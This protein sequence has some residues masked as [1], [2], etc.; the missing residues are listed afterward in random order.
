MIV[1]AVPFRPAPV[2]I[3]QERRL[4]ADVN[5]VFEEDDGVTHPCEGMR[6]PPIRLARRFDRTKRG[7]DAWNLA[8]ERW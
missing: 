6:V 8:R 3:G 7:N 2:G 5:L 4:G 1:R